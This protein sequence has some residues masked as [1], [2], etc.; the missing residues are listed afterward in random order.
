VKQF[1]T[2]ANA[3]NF[4]AGSSRLLVVEA[5]ESDG[6]IVSYRPAQSLIM[7]LDLDHHSIAETGRMFEALSGNTWGDV[8]AGADDHNLAAF[9]IGAAATF[10]IDNE[11]DYRAIDVEYGD[12]GTR[13]RV[14][15][16]TFRLSIPGKHNLYN[17]LACIALLSRAGVRGEEMA[18]LLPE[19]AGIERRFDVHL[20]DG[21]HLV[22]DDYAHNPHKIAGLMQTMAR[23]SPGVCYI[24]QPHGFGPTRMMRE[25]YIKVFAD[26][27]REGD[28]LVLL[29]IYYAGGTAAKDISSQDLADG[30]SAAG[31]S[32][33][34]MER[35]G[36]LAAPLEQKAYVVLGARDDTLADLA[37]EIAKRLR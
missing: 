25:G 1:R 36:L 21:R 12:F 2:A 19:F 37:E 18:R 7:N 14:N 3:G 34:V 26:N 16:T 23:I 8:I 4:T 30:V 24:F 13:F 35:T 9:D 5:C 6:T 28:R 31:R 29:P 17:A 20:N 11:S 27:L 15:G 33:V 32:A 22:V 10:S